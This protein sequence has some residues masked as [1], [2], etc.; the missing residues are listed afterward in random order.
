MKQIMF[1]SKTARFVVCG[2]EPEKFDVRLAGEDGKELDCPLSVL[3]LL[4]ERWGVW[5]V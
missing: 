4:K 2:E 1:I 5:G 3:V